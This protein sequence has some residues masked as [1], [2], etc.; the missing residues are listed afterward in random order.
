MV[1]L[2]K[3]HPTAMRESVVP[4]GILQP[5]RRRVE[6]RSLRNGSTPLSFQLDRVQ[7]VPEYWEDM[8]D[9]VS[10]KTF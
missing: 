7:E 8:Y 5:R 10:A 2:P 1:C 9:V 4:G 6:V 3:V